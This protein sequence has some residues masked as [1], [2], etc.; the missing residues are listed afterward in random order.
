MAESEPGGEIA[1][2]EL[3]ASHDDRDRV[4][5]VLRVS[6]GDGRLSAAE[7]DQR[8]ELALT[9][10]TYGELATLVSDLPA[11]GSVARPP[12]T[13]A[14]P[15]DVVRIDCRSGH[16]RRVD[17][18]MVPQ[19]MEVKVTSGHVELDLTQAVITQPLLRLELDVRSGHV[20][21][22]TKPGIVVDAD[23]VAI[24]S[25]HVKVHAPWG[26]DVPELLRVEVTGT[27]GSGHF[28][29]RPPRRRFWQWLTRQPQPYALAAR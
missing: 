1:R 26:D 16:V 14:K 22:K 15:R 29:A 2:N 13:A 12:A 5:E 3:R 25:G 19:R 4:V 28:L 27:V 8:L 6:A 20:R 23:D 10:R 11:T 9:A 7:L 18:W 17:R 24:R 21:L